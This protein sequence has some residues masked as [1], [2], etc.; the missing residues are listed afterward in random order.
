[1]ANEFA[2]WCIVTI[3]FWS[4]FWI[5]KLWMK[6]LY[7]QNYHCSKLRLSLYNKYLLC[8]ILNTLNI[9]ICIKR[10]KFFHPRK[11]M[12]RS[13]KPWS[14]STI[15]IKNVVFYIWGRF[16]IF[17]DRGQ[18]WKKLL[19]GAHP[20]NVHCTTGARLPKAIFNYAERSLC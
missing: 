12:K 6:S 10:L 4:F 16:Q 19:G 5:T 9:L 14:R 8:L 11:Y 2:W 3:V 15:H 13:S 17:E 7:D 1:M 20:Q 18:S